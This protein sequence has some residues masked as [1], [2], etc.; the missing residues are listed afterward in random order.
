MIRHGYSRLEER[1]LLKGYCLKEL[2]LSSV[3]APAPVVK[4][5]NETFSQMLLRLIDENV[6]TDA[7]T[8]IK[9]NIDRKLFSKIRNDLCYK[10]NK[11]TEWVL[12]LRPLSNLYSLWLPRPPP[13]F[14]RKIAELHRGDRK[15]TP[16]LYA[17]PLILQGICAFL[18]CE[19]VAQ[20]DCPKSWLRP[21]LPR[22]LCFRF[23]NALLYNMPTE[24]RYLT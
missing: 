1:R 14:T 19:K 22:T 6:M 21:I 3:E 9:A 5:M 10:P 13:P 11:P 17:Q 16:T 24:Y 15:Q 12:T 23:P 2:I 8:Y 20:K 4:Q 7:K 18:F